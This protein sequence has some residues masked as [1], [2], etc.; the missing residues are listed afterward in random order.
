MSLINLLVWLII[1]GLVFYVIYWAVSQIP[2]PAPFNVVVR[3]VLALIV[4]IV[5]LSALF[6]GIHV[7]VLLK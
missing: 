3:V 7:P 1:L 5:L 2:L 4:V 6:G